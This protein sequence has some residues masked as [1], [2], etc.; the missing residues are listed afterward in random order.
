MG[1]FTVGW[2]E[3]TLHPSSLLPTTAPGRDAGA[4]AMHGEAL[5]QFSLQINGRAW[6]EEKEQRSSSQWQ[7]EGPGARCQG[8][9]GSHLM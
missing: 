5:G 9:Q 3:R 2:R 4:G 7:P 8:K 1:S 6:E